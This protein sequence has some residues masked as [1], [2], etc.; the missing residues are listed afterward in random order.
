MLTERTGVSIGLSAIAVLRIA[1][2]LPPLLGRTADSE[3]STAANETSREQAGK[4]NMV[5][6]GAQIHTLNTSAFIA[7]ALLAWGV[8]MFN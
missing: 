2:N 1:N 7:V 4:P 6:S 5:C 3:M 8:F